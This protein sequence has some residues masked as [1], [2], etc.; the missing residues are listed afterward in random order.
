[1]IAEKWP[2]SVHVRRWIGLPDSYSRLILVDLTKKM[3]PLRAYVGNFEG[4]VR[5]Y[6]LLDGKIPVLIRRNFERGASSC[7][8]TSRTERDRGSPRGGVIEARVG[9]LRL[10]NEGRI[11]E[12]IL[13][14]D[15][16]QR[17]V[18]VNAKPGANRSLSLPERVPCD[19]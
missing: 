7:C 2:D 3:R 17:P 9:D 8:N 1:M 6:F 16:V 15:A 11:A 13:L 14:P 12:R 4:G 5:K 19:T 10:L 18:V